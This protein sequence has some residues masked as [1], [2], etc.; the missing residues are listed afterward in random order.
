MKEKFCTVC[1]LPVSDWEAKARMKRERWRPSPSRTIPL[2]SSDTLRAMI[3]QGTETQ[4]CYDV[5]QERARLE[6]IA[7]DPTALSPWER[8]HP[9]LKWT[10]ATDP[11]KVKE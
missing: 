7:I 2:L 11:G 8:A 3:A 9:S 1:R 5:L 4:A 10:N 6:V